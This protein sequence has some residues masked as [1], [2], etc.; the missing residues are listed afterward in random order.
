MSDKIQKRNFSDQFRKIIKRSKKKVGYNMDTMRQ[1][2][3]LVV[4]SITVYSYGFPINCTKV[5]QAGPDAM[6]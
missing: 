3:C 2:A 4:N 5:C 6:L 1:S